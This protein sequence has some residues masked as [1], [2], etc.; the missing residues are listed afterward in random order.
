MRATG[1]LAIAAIVLVQLAGTAA[2]AA[3][4]DDCIDPK[5]SDDEGI[6]ACTRVISSSASTSAEKGIA[7]IGRAQRYYTQK[8]YDRAIEDFDRAIPLKPRWIMLAYGNRANA[9]AL[10]GEDLTAIESYTKAI[11][12]DPTYAAAFTGRGLLYEKAGQIDKARAD[13]KSALAV[14]SIFYDNNWAHD[15]AQSHLD[16][17]KDK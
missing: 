10:K 4:M 13:Y 8:Q 9:Y 16:A 3:P 6:K 1:R 15:T 7:Y 14:K 17:L 2:R 11:E 5:V 12:I